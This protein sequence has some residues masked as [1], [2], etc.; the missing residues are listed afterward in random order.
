MPYAELGPDNNIVSVVA[1]VTPFELDS[2]QMRQINGHPM[3]HSAFDY[4][5]GVLVLNESRVEEWE[6]NRALRRLPAVVMAR[7]DAAIPRYALIKALLS[8][9]SGAGT[10][11]V[12][13]IIGYAESLK[14]RLEA[15]ELVDIDDGWP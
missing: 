4:T 14:A 13:G 8:G 7:I 15:G 12:M 1:T 6:I 11:R 9:G 10:A 3:G 5:G 2:A